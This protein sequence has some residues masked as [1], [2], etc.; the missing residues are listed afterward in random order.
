MR[1]LTWLAGISWALALLYPAQTGFA[2]GAE[3]LTRFSIDLASYRGYWRLENG[4]GTEVSHDEC[5]A[6]RVC[7]ETFKTLPEGDYRLVLSAQPQST[8]VRF[9]VAGGQIAIT[10]GAS[11][12]AADGLTL[13]LN[14]L[15]KVVFD[16]NGYR[17]AWSLDLWKGAEATGFFKRDGGQQMIELFPDT[18]YTLN[19]GPFAAERFQIRRDDKIVMI[20]DSGAVKLKPEGSNRLQFQ[21]IDAVFYPVPDSDISTWQIE[22]LPLPDARNAFQGGKILRLVQGTKYKVSEPKTDAAS[23]LET[24]T[25]GKACNMVSQRPRLTKID[26]HVMPI[27]ASCAGRQTPP[28][29]A[30]L[31]TSRRNNA[32]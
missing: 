11:I 25:T 2:A 6:Q 21:T 19:I 4:Q 1:K 17:G 31:G 3:K 13:R 12:A 23:V 27:L 20:D 22:G 29:E 24:V 15:R 5:F 10:S 8:P 18:T 28:A 14:S 26:L 7:R 9:K 32:P 16:T 30:D